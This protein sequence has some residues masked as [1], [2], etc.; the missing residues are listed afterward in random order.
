MPAAARI[1]LYS[2][3]KGA[4]NPSMSFDFLFIK[5]EVR[6]IEREKIDVGM[7]VDCDINIWQCPPGECL[8]LSNLEYD[9]YH[10][11][12]LARPILCCCAA[13]NT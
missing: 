12:P 7:L 3:Q 9:P 5:L 4:M 8:G 1:E 11:D 13:A 2:E 6:K 10:R